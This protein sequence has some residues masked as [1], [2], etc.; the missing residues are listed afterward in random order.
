MSEVLDVEELMEECEDDR[1]MLAKWVE[2]FERDCEDRSP[3]WEQAVAMGDATQIL[4]QAHAV[5]GSVGTFFAN[6]AFESA[7]QLE[8]MG[9]EGRLQDSQTCWATLQ[10]QLTELRQ[11]LNKLVQG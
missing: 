4:E 11:E 2:I 10:S 3:K 7:F 5:K 1:Q 9:R 8:T 6:A